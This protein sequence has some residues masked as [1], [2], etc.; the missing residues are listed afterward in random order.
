MSKYTAGELSGPLPFHSSSLSD[1]LTSKRFPKAALVECIA[2]QPEIQF[3]KKIS[4]RPLKE[5]QRKQLIRALTGNF[6]YLKPVVESLSRAE[7]RDFSQYVGFQD[8]IHVVFRF[9]L[10][11]VFMLNFIVQ[12]Q[13]CHEDK[14]RDELSAAVSCNPV[15]L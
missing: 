14:L 1:L 7:T 4:S 8:A 2:R 12:P 11:C 13:V 9:H 10:S 5:I 3:P 6:G 15:P